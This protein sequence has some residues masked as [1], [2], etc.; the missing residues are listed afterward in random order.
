MPYLAFPSILAGS[1]AARWLLLVAI[2][3]L[4]AAVFVVVYRLLGEER[5]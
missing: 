2:V 1:G 5:Y 3:G 4:V